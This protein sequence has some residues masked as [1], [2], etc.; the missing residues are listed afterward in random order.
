MKTKEEKIAEVAELKQ[1]LQEYPVVALV[2]FTGVPASLMQNIRRDGRGQLEIKVARRTLIERALKE[3]GRPKLDALAS[4]IRGQPALVFSKLSPLQLYRFFEARKRRAPAKPGSTSSSDVVLHAGELD[5][6]PGPA[7]SALQKLGAK[8]RIQAGRVT[9]LEDFKLLSAGQVVDEEI[10]DLLVKL[11]ILPVE[12]AMKFLVVWENGL[13]YSPDLLQVDEKKL[14]QDL[15]QA[16]LA[17]LNLSVNVLYP[18]AQTLPLL[19]GK[20]HT[21]ACQLALSVNYPVKEILPVLLS[22]AS[23]QAFSLAKGLQGKNPLLDESLKTLLR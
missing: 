10:S 6:P 5:L 18:I 4:H 17:A 8:V 1:K 16:H 13:I 22:R 19:I 15:Q 14:S 23:L 7:V 20:A 11:D 9:L 3:A 2:D 21:S 12:Q